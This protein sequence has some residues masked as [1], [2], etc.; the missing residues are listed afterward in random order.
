[1]EYLVVLALFVLFLKLSLAKEDRSLKKKFYT[2]R[3]SNKYSFKSFLL[4]IDH[5]SSL[6]SSY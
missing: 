2:D 1:M 3:N 5:L 6:C 4:Y